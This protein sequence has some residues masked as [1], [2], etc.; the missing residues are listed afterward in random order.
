MIAGFFVRQLA[1]LGVPPQ[2]RKAAFWAAVIALLIAFLALG[3][4]AYDRKVIRDHEAKVERRAAPATNKAAEE[5]AHDTI[6]L[7]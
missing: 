6:A 1:R 5:R 4:C 7:P 3:K 2:F